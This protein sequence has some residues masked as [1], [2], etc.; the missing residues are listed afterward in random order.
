M[1][2]RRFAGSGHATQTYNLTLNRV[3][4]RKGCREGQLGRSCVVLPKVY[5]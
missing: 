5:R 4:I 3:F 2:R 1:V